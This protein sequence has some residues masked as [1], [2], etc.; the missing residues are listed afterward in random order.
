M[1]TVNIS[2]G[3]LRDQNQNVKTFGRKR[4]GLYSDVID[5]CKDVLLSYILM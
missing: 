3:S 2:H 1:E 5:V 4:S